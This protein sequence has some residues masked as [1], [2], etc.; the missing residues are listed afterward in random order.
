MDDWEKKY[1]D[2]IEDVTSSE[3]TV[4]VPE[5]TKATL[6]ELRKTAIAIVLRVKEEMDYKNL[7]LVDKAKTLTLVNEILVRKWY[8]TKQD[9]PK[10]LSE[11]TQKIENL[12]ELTLDEKIEII[13][14]LE[15]RKDHIL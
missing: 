5:D 1:P 7:S 13:H 2:K 8:F 12:I 11:L 6:D 14:A 9:S 4:K 3:H 10:F 15:D